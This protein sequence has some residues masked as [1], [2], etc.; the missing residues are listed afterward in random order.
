MILLLKTSIV[1]LLLAIGMA[2]TPGDIVY[3][4]RRPLLLGKAVLAMYVVMPLVAITMARLLDLPRGTELALVILAVCAGAPLLPKKLIKAG[5][6]PAFVFSLIVTT[7]LAA[8]VTVPLSLHFLVSDAAFDTAGVTPT[9]VAWLILTSLVAPMG[10]GMLL[11]RAAPGVAERIG[12]P[13]LRVAGIVMSVCALIALVAGFHLVFDVGVPSLAAFAAFTLA[14]ILAGHLLG[15]PDPSDRTS[16]AVACASRHIGLALLIAANARREQTLALVVAYLLASALVS[17]PYIWLRTRGSA[18]RGDQAPLATN[19]AG[20]AMLALLVCAVFSTMPSSAW[21]A[22][23]QPNIVVI[24]ADDLGNADLGYRGGE[25]RTPNLDALARGGVRLEAFYGEP[26]CTPARAALMT[27]RYPMR[28]GLQTLVIFPSHTYGLPT[29]ERTLPQALKEAG[30]D[31]AMVGKW[32][33]GHADRKYWPQNRGFD[34]FYGNVV[35]EVDYFTHERGGVIDWQ[36]NGEFV[37]EP[38][39]YTELIGDEAVRIITAHDPKRPL[40]LYVASLAPHA[41]Y[42]APQRLVDTYA[43]I[44]DPLRRTYAAMITSLDEQVGRIVAALAG[45][46]M[47]DDTILVF[48]S[49]NGGAT[50]ALF[51]TGARSPEERAESGGVELHAKPPASNGQLRDGKGS[52]HEGGVRVPAIVSWPSHLK[53]A[54]VNEPLHMVDVMPTLLARAGAHGSADHP[55]D[56]KDMWPTL[57]DGAPSPN[58]DILINVEAFRGAIR[59]G[60]WKLV[61]IALLPGKVELFDLEKDPG[62]TTDLAAANPEVVADLRARLRRY[63]SE[64][65]PSEWLKA[66]PAFL[67]AQ[68]RTVIDPDFDID[69]GGLPHEKPVLPQS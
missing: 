32:H 68:G 6:N 10:A 7:S 37:R 39:Y 27:G 60:K 15:G 45:K 30:Y 19:A 61:E 63:A 54:V 41:P 33:L 58:E 31:T 53:P 13:L 43:S 14:A 62:E 69:D 65:K 40:F 36:R 50:N 5:G 34:S 66:Q 64:Q 46:K 44:D 47:L 42:Q 35:G 56:G 59:K 23:R 38:G 3:L 21:A 11:R 29:D 8:I 16:L 24:L 2:A 55:F 67:G 17:I 52:L 25:V 22:D 28:H 57:A 26:V 20:P 4:W 48:S 9:R 51:A 1:A 49:D 12:G 18:K